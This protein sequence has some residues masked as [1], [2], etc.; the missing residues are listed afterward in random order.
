MQ[1]FW[2][3]SFHSLSSTI[4]Q[5]SCSRYAHSEK[6]SNRLFSLE[7][8]G[9]LMYSAGQTNNPD[10]E[11]AT[12]EAADDA[13]TTN[14][15]VNRGEREKTPADNADN[16]D[17]AAAANNNSIEPLSINFLFACVFGRCGD[18]SASVRAQA[19]KTLG[20]ITTEQVTLSSDCLIQ[21][22]PLIGWYNTNVWLVDI[23][24][25][26]DWFTQY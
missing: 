26:F 25:S 3:S 9:R 11:E 21:K 24:L 14:E 15:S 4:Y 17:E 5:L 13:P 20:D 10:D 6:A 8:V 12:G 23:I 1:Q 22:Y 18:S 7:V 16:D 2:I 19:L